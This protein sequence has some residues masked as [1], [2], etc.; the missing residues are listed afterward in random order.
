M[1]PTTFSRKPATLNPGPRPAPRDTNEAHESGTLDRAGRILA[2]YA[3]GKPI[4]V[5]AE[6]SAAVRDYVQGRRTQASQPRA[7]RRTASAAR[8]SRE[9]LK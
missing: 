1:A 7:R 4:R 9:K 8:M 5:I 3:A 6:S 2:G